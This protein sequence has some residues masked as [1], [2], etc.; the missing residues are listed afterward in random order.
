MKR[1]ILI[2]IIVFVGS[3]MQAQQTTY[4]TCSSIKKFEGNWICSNGFDTIRVTL[5][6]ARVYDV[7]DNTFRDLLYGWHE[8]KQGNTIIESIYQNRFMTISNIDSVSDNSCSIIITNNLF[9]CNQ[10]SFKAR[11]HIID[12]LQSKEGHNVYIEI[13]AALNTINWRQEHAEGFGVFTGAYG[14]TLP[15]QFTLLRQ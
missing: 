14:M 6:Y 5:R 11:G 3:Q 4:D 9:P 2:L 1:Y 8:Y 13:N 7:D 10:S 15:K 12:Y